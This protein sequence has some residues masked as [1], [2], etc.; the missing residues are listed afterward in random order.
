MIRVGPV[1]VAA[2][3]LLALSACDGGDGGGPSVLPPPPDAEPPPPPVGDEPPP[4]G[5]PRPP[6]AGGETFT[7]Y[8]E[9]VIGFPELLATSSARL[10]EIAWDE[11]DRVGAMHRRGGT[12][13][14]QIV[15]LTDSGAHMDHPD[16]EGQFAH[17]CAVGW[18]CNDR[19]DIPAAAD[20]YGGRDFSSDLWDGDGH[21]TQVAGVVAARKNGAGVYGIAYEAGVASYANQVGQL[22][23]GCH[24][25]EDCHDRGHAWGEIFDRENARGVRWMQG[26]G[27]R[28]ASNSWGRFLHRQGVTPQS[29]TAAR[30]RSIMAESLP[31]YEA[32]VAAGG[33]MVWA[34]GNQ[35]GDRHPYPEVEGVLPRFFPA[36]EKG[37]L[38]VGGFGGDRLD[39]GGQ[40]C[41]EAAAWCV[42]A[43]YVVA[44]TAVDGLWTLAVGT[45]IAAPYAAAAL[46]AL[47]S[48]FPNLSHQ[49]V[50]E[51]I[52]VTA[53]DA[54]P[55]YSRHIYG[56][57]RIDVEKAS[58]P[59]GG[60]YFALGAR[61][62]GPVVS[63]AGARAGLPGGAI[64]RYFA[65]RTV[66]VLD[67]FQRAP[68]E[69]GLEAFAEAR[70]SGYLSL[71]DLALAPLRRGQRS[72]GEG[73]AVVAVSGTGFQ[74]HGLA[75][76]GLLVGFGRGAGV[77]QGLAELAGSPLVAGGWRMS[78]DAAGIALGLSG[79]SG[80]WH[81]V[82]VSGTAGTGAPGF[83]IAGWN[84]AAVLAASFAPRR[85]GG[86]GGADA[87]G[88]SFASGLGRPMGWDG[89]GAL[90]IAGDSAGLAWRRIVPA[91]ET[92]R[93][94]LTGRVT[95]LA[96]RSGPLLRFDD[97]LLAAADLVISFR[98]HRLVTV[99]ARLGA[100]R[101][102]AVVSGRIRAATGVD[103]SGQIAYQ[104]IVID[105]RDLLSFDRAGL[106][107]VFADDPNAALGLGVAAVRDGFG[108][109]E[110]LAGMR[111]DLEF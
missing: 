7:P 30:L 83:G 80:E 38:T 107:V 68:F 100:E 25:H 97:V 40:P 87:F 24:R 64:G 99:A 108:R 27:V 62:Q 79:A 14:G 60:T 91:G 63:T 111:M 29:Y 19:G 44:T 78:K 9:V 2:A 103:E 105:G 18:T 88:V 23:E 48:M 53:D 28:V 49:E 32:Y 74:A 31:A 61:D 5:D 46:A 41:G 71:D 55:G 67:G 101:P 106:S 34:N 11:A 56:Q 39:G 47:K 36:L 17:V 59:V 45:S 52:L 16:L 10:A 94:D 6:P 22:H 20:R 26:L 81:A 13:R 70:R 73:R 42:A 66:T 8:R 85:A 102:A 98:P 95:R 76:G 96:V 33:V 3:A 84:P 54:F 58:R 50:R 72:G 35:P 1:V 69:V 4:G 92:G 110:A 90:E 77:A 82:G 93:L 75:E 43:P 65:G 15:G 109:T 104:D 12:G 21:G 57:G 51:R 86:A 37:W 89:A